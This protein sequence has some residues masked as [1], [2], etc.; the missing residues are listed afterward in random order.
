MGI[1]TV[2]WLETPSPSCP[3]TAVVEYNTH[4][5]YN[6]KR[7]NKNSPG[8]NKS[9]PE[10][11]QNMPPVVVTPHV[12]SC[13]AESFTNLSLVLTSVGTPKFNKLPVPN[14]PFSPV[15]IIIIQRE[16]KAY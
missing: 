7:S 2:A 14:A 3:L 16:L 13:P 4:S 10:P 8:T 15:Y 6:S 9:L 12:C 11:Q 1:G 5:Q